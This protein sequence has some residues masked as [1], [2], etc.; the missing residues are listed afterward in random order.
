MTP[1]QIDIIKRM[2]EGWRLTQDLCLKPP[3]G[4]DAQI[5]VVYRQTIT[6][7]HN[8]KLI[9]MNVYHS[10]WILTEDGK[11]GALI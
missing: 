9:C 3:P 10:A 11:T 4:L 7:L 1:L 5:I 6:A 2:R 8:R